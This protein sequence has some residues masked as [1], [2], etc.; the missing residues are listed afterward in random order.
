MS[1]TMMIRVKASNIVN[2]LNATPFSNEVLLTHLFA[3]RGTAEQ[4][5]IMDTVRAQ[6][7]SSCL[8]LLDE[9]VITVTSSDYAPVDDE[10]VER[11]I[12]TLKT[13]SEAV[14]P[15]QADTFKEVA[16]LNTSFNS[17]LQ[18]LEELAQVT[19]TT[20]NAAQGSIDTAIHALL[21]NYN[22]SLVVRTK[23]VREF[24]NTI[25]EAQESIA[26]LHGNRS[27]YGV[28]NTAEARALEVILAR[29]NPMHNAKYIK[30]MRMQD[31]AAALAC[32]ALVKKLGKSQAYSK[33]LGVDLSQF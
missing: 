7:A 32:L 2:A 11:S 26:A 23:L 12:G 15:T 33:H 22:E 14:P 6:I 18:D 20:N 5:A 19:A 30:D 27:A 28:G 24:I 21:D 13:I 29:G 25:A 9:A 31:N 8:P 10:L 16:A 17:M 3:I 4:N 1:N